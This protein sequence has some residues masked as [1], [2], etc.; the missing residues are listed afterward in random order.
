MA[1]KLI[2]P[3]S[4]EPITLEE[5]KAHIRVDGADE[6]ILI[7]SLIT[8]ARE[9][10]ESFQNRAY[11]TQ[12]WELILDAFPASPFNI[13]RPPLQSVDSIK[14]TDS[15]GLETTF[16]STNYIVDTDSEPGRV[17]LA[18]GIVWPSMTLKSIG[19]VKIRFTAGYGDAAAVPMMIKQAMLLLIGHWYENREA[20]FIGH[21]SREIEF[22]VH[23][24][25]WPERVFPI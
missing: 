14:Y 13:P 1:L 19:G 8:T 10:C 11:I 2:T 16:D 7:T 5:A 6:D 25:L 18:T 22:A 15:D 3:P 4:I 9:Y 21:V 17:A 20:S 24:L 23:A 12:V